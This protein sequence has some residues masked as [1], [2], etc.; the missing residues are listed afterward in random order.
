MTKDFLIIVRFLLVGGTGAV[1]NLGLFY[2][3]T[4][5]LG[6]WYLISSVI[7]VVF[8]W[9]VSF[10]LHKFLTF[11]NHNLEQSFNQGLL[12]LLV[13][14]LSLILNSFLL[15]FLVEYWQSHYFLAQII[16]SGLLAGCNFFVYRFLVFKLS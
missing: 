6:Y 1:V 14:I 11:R 9:I 8:S 12:Y 2:L 3:L 7:A 16:V 5:K 10:T 4:E 13:G 15:L